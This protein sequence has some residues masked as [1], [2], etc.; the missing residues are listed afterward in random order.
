MLR[1]TRRRFLIRISNLE[2]R[3]GIRIAVTAVL[4]DL[5]AAVAR[6]ATAYEDV[7]GDKGTRIFSSQE[8]FRFLGV[9]YLC[10]ALARALNQLARED[11][12]TALPIGVGV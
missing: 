8:V 9:L 4:A 7:R 2:F 1:R 6:V 11:A 12:G 10:G 5:D 3:L